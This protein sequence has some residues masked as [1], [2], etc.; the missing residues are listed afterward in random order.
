MATD[1]VSRV[2]NDPNFIEL[3]RKR[4]GLGVTLAVTMLVI[5]YGYI[6]L[7]AFAKPFLSTIIGGGVVTYAFPIG[8]FVL[9]SA[10]VITGIYVWR[11]NTEFDGLTRKIMEKN[12]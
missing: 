1:L 9:V 2:M 7:L 4:N 11:A 8:L 5:Y 3:E 6:A 10:I 12:L